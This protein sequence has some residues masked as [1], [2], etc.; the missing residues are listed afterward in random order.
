MSLLEH[1]LAA[2]KSMSAITKG[3]WTANLRA[4]ELIERVSPPLAIRG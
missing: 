1:L 2:W 4:P 3:R